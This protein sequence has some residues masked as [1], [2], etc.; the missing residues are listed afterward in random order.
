MG[1]AART[2]E[3]KEDIIGQR[4]GMTARHPGTIFIGVTACGLAEDPGRVAM[5]QDEVLEKIYD[6]N[7][8]RP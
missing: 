4:T 5:W 1:S 6:K 7:A 3:V 8:R 2:N